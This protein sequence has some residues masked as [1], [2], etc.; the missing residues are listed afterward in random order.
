MLD[1]YLGEWVYKIDSKKKCER[2]YQEVWG[3][4]FPQD[5]EC[6]KADENVVESFVEF[7]IT[8]EMATQD[9]N[10]VPGTYTLKGGTTIKPSDDELASI[11]QYNKNVLNQAFN[12]NCE[13]DDEYISCNRDFEDPS[14]LSGYAELGRATIQQHNISCDAR[15]V[16]FGMMKGYMFASCGDWERYEY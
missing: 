2:S 1:E 10:L 6:V 4:Y 7:I 12:G 3:E 13:I 14:K 5:L 11:F 8:E 16:R 15:T 9:S